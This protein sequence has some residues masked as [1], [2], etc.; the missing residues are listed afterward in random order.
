MSP[1]KNSHACAQRGAER[2]SAVVA[3]LWGV[4]LIESVL[5]KSTLKRD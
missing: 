1:A 4:D 3:A 5:G 2:N